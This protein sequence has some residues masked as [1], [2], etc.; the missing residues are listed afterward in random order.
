MALSGLFPRKSWRAA[1]GALALG[2]GLAGISATPAQ[3]HDGWGWEHRD[4]DRGHGWDNDW[5]RDAWREHEWRERHPYWGFGY[6]APPVT[7][8]AP[9]YY[10][11]SYS[12]GV[13]VYIPLR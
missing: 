6:Y 1:L 11:P 12:P 3:A 13:S 7:Y 4:Y 5:R 8:A 9:Q 10:Y 2:A